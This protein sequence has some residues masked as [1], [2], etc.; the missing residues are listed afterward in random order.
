VEL[1]LDPVAHKRTDPYFTKEGPGGG[2]RGVN[3]YFHGRGIFAFTGQPGKITGSDFTVDAR[4]A[5][6]KMLGEATIGRFGALAVFDR[7][8]S[9][10]E[11]KNIHAA[12]IVAALH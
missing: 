7:A 4:Y 10:A 11:L 12:A 8:L 5:V 3:P 1:D 6:G 2:D 9:D